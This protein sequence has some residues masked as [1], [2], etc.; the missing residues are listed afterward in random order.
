MR[1]ARAR[2]AVPATALA[3]ALVGG[4]E[5]YAE[6]GVRDPAFLPAPH[7]IAAALWSNAGLMA[8][9]LW[10]TA[11]IVG[12]GLAMALALGAGAALAVHLWAPA[13]RALYPLAVGSQAI[14]VAVLAPL[15]V[16][17]LGFGM[18]PKLPVVALVCFFP[19]LVTTV[20]ALAGVEPAKV[21]LLR[22]L[23]ASR[24]QC[25][26]FAELPAA[27]P[28]A[29]SGARIAVAVGV[30]GADI[31]ETATAGTSSGIGHQVQL[32]L[33]AVT[34]QQTPRA[35]AGTVVLFLFALACFQLF[36]LAERLLRPGERPHPARGLCRRP[37]AAALDAPVA[38]ATG[39]PP[40]SA[41]LRSASS[42]GAAR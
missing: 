14:P 11:Q 38:G 1:L 10:S 23:G 2:A 33:S 15:L 8:S 12:L 27:L 22:S 17:W 18:A 9:N 21:A 6:L 16:L 28:G 35:W 26:R 42:A 34:A 20:D 25:F 31:A 29:L 37:V 5:A 32:D 4:W 41:A 30:I 40:A 13:R 7:A 24:W 36:G 3:A 19:V 39:A